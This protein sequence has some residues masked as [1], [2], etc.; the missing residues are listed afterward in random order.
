LVRRLTRARFDVLLQ[1]ELVHPSLVFLNDWLRARARYPIVTIAHLLRS[2]EK[3]A[4]RLRGFYSAAE[5]RYLGTVDAALYNSET[6][7]RAVEALLRRGLPGIIA[8]P[9]G[10]HLTVERSETELAA[11]ARATEPLHVLSIAN[12][13][14]GKGNLRPDRRTLPPARRELAFTGRRQLDD[15]PAL[16]RSPAGSDRSRRSRHQC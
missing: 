10:D 15:G 5:R 13:L 6:T 14:P 11:Q 16:R 8:Y 3:T 1:D 9:G 12:V 4:A 7:R 2:N